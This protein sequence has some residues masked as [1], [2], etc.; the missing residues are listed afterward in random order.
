MLHCTCVM[1]TRVMVSCVPPVVYRT[2]EGITQYLAGGLA[3]PDLHRKPSACEMDCCIRQ[4]LGSRQSNKTLST[5]LTI[6]QFLSSQLGIWASC[7]YQAS[8]E[9]GHTY[10][11]TI[12]QKHEGLN[13]F[14]CNTCPTTAASA[15]PYDE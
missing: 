15:V 3:Q 2:W 14:R 1:L 4:T 6:K 8:L 11:L 7:S 5:K 10:I 13:V 12:R 9:F